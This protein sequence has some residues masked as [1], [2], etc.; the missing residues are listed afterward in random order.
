MIDFLPWSN[1]IHRY[2]DRLPCT[3]HKHSGG[4]ISGSDNHRSGLQI[5]RNPG[6]SEAEPEAD[7]GDDLSACEGYAFN[8]RQRIR[9]RGDRPRHFYGLQ[10]PAS[11]GPGVARYLE[12]NE[13]FG[14]V[15]AAHANGSRVSGGLAPSLWR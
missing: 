5:H 15:Q 1:R 3:I 10:E 6:E 13:T 14:L 12:E 4:T 11:N 2:E 9:N 8:E 7:P